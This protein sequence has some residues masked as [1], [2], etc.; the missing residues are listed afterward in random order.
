MVMGLL[1][2]MSWAKLET[3]TAL[4]KRASAQFQEHV[5]S[6]DVGKFSGSLKVKMKPL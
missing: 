1:V 2:G 5:L 6:L 4:R 3:K